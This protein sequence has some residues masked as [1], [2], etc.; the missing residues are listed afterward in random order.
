M[1]R[2]MRKPLSTSPS[3]IFVSVLFLFLSC[4]AQEEKEKENTNSS[5]SIAH[6]VLLSGPNSNMQAEEYRLISASEDLLL[7]VVKINRS[8]SPP[9]RLPQVDFSSESVVL[10]NMGQKTTG[11]YSYIVERIA[12]EANSWV[13]EYRKIEPKA[14]EMA[15][16]VMTT[17][18]S[19]IKIPRPDKTV[20]FREITD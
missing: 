16:T 15:V 5:Q 14:G 12:E 13:V 1:K 7:V 2:S 18:Y 10:L 20:S 19:L 4:K 6:E 17:P 8:V 9:H 11:G 3:I